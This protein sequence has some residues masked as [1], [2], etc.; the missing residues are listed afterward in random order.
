MSQLGSLNYVMTLSG[1]KTQ[2]SWWRRLLGLQGPVP[3]RG[4]GG[5]YHHSGGGR[6]RGGGGP[7]LPRH[8]YDG[9]GGPAFPVTYG[10]PSPTCPDY[11]APVLGSDGQVYQNWCY[12]E[13]AGVAVVKQLGLRGPGLGMTVDNWSALLTFVAGVGIAWAVTTH[14]S[15]KA[16]ARAR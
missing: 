16:R 9:G 7:L 4:G 14:A 12:A 6:P 5:G 11:Y 2:P 1:M 3:R 15:K 10:G 8:H 13:M